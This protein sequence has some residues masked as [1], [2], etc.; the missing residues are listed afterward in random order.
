MQNYFAIKITLFSEDVYNPSDQSFGSLR[1][2]LDQF[3][4]F[5][6]I[7]AHASDWLFK[8]TQYCSLYVGNGQHVNL[9]QPIKELNELF[10]KLRT[11][12]NILVNHSFIDRQQ[13]QVKIETRFDT[14]FIPILDRNWSAPVFAKNNFRWVGKA[15]EAE[16]EDCIFLDYFSLVAFFVEF[17]NRLQCPHSNLRDKI[18]ILDKF[19]IIRII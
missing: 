1:T 16:V 5:R 11:S 15:E 13:R 7:H 6:G 19:T 3:Q 8:Q 10:K 12:G 18:I 2:V 17:I 14:I 4:Q 9:G